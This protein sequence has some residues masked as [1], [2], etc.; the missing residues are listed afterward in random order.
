MLQNNWQQKSQEN[1]SED[2]S[3]N[4]EFMSLVLISQI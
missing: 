4:P 1:H 2:E 3:E